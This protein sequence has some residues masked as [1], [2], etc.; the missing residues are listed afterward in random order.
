MANKVNAWK[1][2]RGE[3]FHTPQEA[4]REDA[5]DYL[6]QQIRGHVPK[7]YHARNIAK[8]LIDSPAELIRLLNSLQGT[9]DRHG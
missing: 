3:L 7:P 9:W 2:K 8:A 1:S 4:R 6:T 5:I